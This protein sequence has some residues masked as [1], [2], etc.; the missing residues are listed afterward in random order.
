V[1]SSWGTRP[2]SGSPASRSTILD[3]DEA[4]RALVEMVGTF[5]GRIDAWL[6]AEGIEREGELDALVAL[7]VP[8]AQGFHLGRP[9]P[10]W[11]PL[12][13]EADRQLAGQPRRHTGPTL[14]TLLEHP[15][16]VTDAALAFAAFTDP[17]VDLVVL[18]D[19]D[20]RPI[21]GLDDRSAPL[22]LLTLDM[23]INLDTSPSDAALRAITRIGADWARPLLC[24]DNA[25]RYVGVVRMPRLLHALASGR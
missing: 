13:P 19:D 9:A 2:S 11:A 3:Q 10:P 1:V 8:L 24:T 21:A 5:A 6:L 15:P 14:R 23:R 16:V 25:G 20:L 18:C 12:R 17:S 22:P 4:K 7:R